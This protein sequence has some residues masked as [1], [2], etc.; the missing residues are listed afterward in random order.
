MSGEGEGEG[1]RVIMKL[2][3][4]WYEGIIHVHVAIACMQYEKSDRKLGGATCIIPFC[5]CP[6][7]PAHFVTHSAPARPLPPTL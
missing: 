1:G 5:T 7:S 6:T 3:K 4:T 2:D